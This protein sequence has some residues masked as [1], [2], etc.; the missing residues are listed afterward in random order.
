MVHWFVVQPGDPEIVRTFPEALAMFPV[1]SGGRV[2]GTP[3]KVS[4]FARHET[5]VKPTGSV[6]TV[7]ARPNDANASRKTVQMMGMIRRM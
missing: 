2:N 7:C 5:V 4:E 1:N 3:R 6:A